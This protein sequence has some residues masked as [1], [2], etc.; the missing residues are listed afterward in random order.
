MAE[1]NSM[2]NALLSDRSHFTEQEIHTIIDFV[3]E[4]DDDM[5]Y[6]FEN[7]EER[8]VMYSYEQLLASSRPIGINNGGRDIELGLLN[9]GPNTTI[10]NNSNFFNRFNTRVP[11]LGRRAGNIYNEATK[12]SYDYAG[13]VIAGIGGIF[14]VSAGVTAVVTTGSEAAK[15]A[16]TTG[17]RTAFLVAG[18]FCGVVGGF[19]VLLRNTMSDRQTANNKRF[20]ETVKKAVK[21]RTKVNKFFEETNNKVVKDPAKAKTQL[22]SGLAS[23]PARFAAGPGGSTVYADLSPVEKLITEDFATQH[24]DIRSKVVISRGNPWQITLTTLRGGT[25]QFTQ[26]EMTV[27]QNI[28]SRL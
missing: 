5:L 27:L 25:K 12:I 19:L 14:G 2:I 7:A 9:S 13:K 1:I 10:Q 28:A 22:E 20:L 26:E 21:I 6:Q 24:Y 17:V 16:S 8:S 23:H 18:G 3:N 15:A 4:L 11:L